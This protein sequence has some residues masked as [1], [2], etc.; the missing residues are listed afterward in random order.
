MHWKYLW[1]IAEVFYNDI[2][3]VPW[4]FVQHGLLIGHEES[5]RWL[6]MAEMIMK[7]LRKFFHH[8]YINHSKEVGEKN[9]V[10]NTYSI[11]I[12]IKYEEKCEQ[13]NWYYCSNK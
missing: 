11:Y 1:T 9:E 12:F 2:Y 10:D 7:V 3:D 4:M 6:F 8:D 5:K 13:K